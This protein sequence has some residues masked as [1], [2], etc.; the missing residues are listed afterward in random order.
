MW[1]AL[2][3]AEGGDGGM[4]LQGG[5]IVRKAK[6]VVLERFGEEPGELTDHEPASCIPGRKEK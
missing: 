2:V 5:E 1:L 3:R 6:R 4:P